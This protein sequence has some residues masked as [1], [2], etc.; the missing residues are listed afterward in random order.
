MVI[1][2]VRHPPLPESNPLSDRMGNTN[3]S[4]LVFGGLMLLEL[5]LGLA[6]IRIGSIRT[7]YVVL[8]FVVALS[9]IT[10]SFLLAMHS[11]GVPVIHAF[12]TVFA[13]STLTIYIIVSLRRRKEPVNVHNI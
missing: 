5:M 10:S 6:F 3:N 11:G 4:L 13:T 8:V 7:I 1:D 2:F 12:W 9:L